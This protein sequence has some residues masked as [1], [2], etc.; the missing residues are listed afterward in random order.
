MQRF[1]N[2]PRDLIGKPGQPLDVI[3]RSGLQRLE[4]AKV[5]DE[6]LLAHWTEP[7]NVIQRSRDHLLAPQLSV[8]G[9]RKSVRFI[10]D[11]LKHEERLTPAFEL[12]GILTTRYE[13][14]F[15]SLRK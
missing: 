7:L 9:V 11:V 5:S 12:D 3:Q 15:K 13:Y 14:L 6:T 2:A 10:T 8:K 4:R 1:V